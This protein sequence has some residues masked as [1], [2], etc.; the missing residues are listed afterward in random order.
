MSD[1]SIGSFG[2]STA[3]GLT[4]WGEEAGQAIPQAGPCNWPVN[5]GAGCFYLLEILVDCCGDL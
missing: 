1:T 3:G 2:L 5:L 4:I